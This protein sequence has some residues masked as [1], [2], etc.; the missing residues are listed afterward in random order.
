M[1]MIAFRAHISCTSC[2]L[3]LLCLLST[4]SAQ[5]SIPIGK[6]RTHISFNSVT[7]IT[8]SDTKVY[9][10][11]ANGLMVLDKGS[12]ELSAL[13]SLNGLTGKFIHAIHFDGISA[14]LLVGYED[15]SLDIIH[16]T[17]ITNL[18]WLQGIPLSVPRSANH[19]TVSGGLAYLSTG[20][21][22]AVI[23][24]AKRE[25]KEVWRDLA[26]DGSPLSIHQS[27]ILGDS[28]FLATGK[29]V[30]SGALGDNLLDFHKWNR[31]DTA[32]FDNPIKAVCSF[33][34]RIYAS[35]DGAGLFHL[36]GGTW[37]PEDFPQDAAV[38]SLTSSTAHLV[39]CVSD[40][41]WLLSQD[42][43]LDN[44]GSSFMTAFRY[45]WEDNDGR[46]WIADS[47][48]GLLSASD[49]FVAN[50]PAFNEPFRL[51]FLDGKIVALGGGYT[52]DF[53]PLERP[54][55]LSFFT[56]GKWNTQKA[57]LNDLTS[58]QNVGGVVF[59]S[60]YGNGIQSGP[61]DSPDVIYT[62]SNSS[63]PNTNIT[64][65]AVDGNGLW[66]A[67]YGAMSPLHW[68]EGGTWHP[69]SFP[70]TAARYPLALT[71]DYSGSL[72]AALSPSSGG[73]VLVFNREENLTAYLTD[74][75]GN[76][77]LP[78][79]NVRCLASDRDGAIWVGTDNG[80]AYF[81]N[82]AAV[83]GTDVNAT[84]PIYMNRFLLDGERVSAIA[85]DG[86]NR[87]WLGTERGVWLF[88]PDG[89][90]L[91]HNFTVANSP[92]PSNNIR[93]IAINGQDG[94]VFM[95]TDR[96]VVSFRSDATASDGNFSSTRIFP[97]PVTS[98]FNGM[99]GISGLAQ[100]AV[101]KITDISG[102]L[103]W[104]TRAAG[105]TASWNVRHYNGQ[106]ATT[107]IYLV[108]SA[109]DDGSQKFVGKIAVVD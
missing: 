41:V 81:S 93:N 91:I 55:S 31:Y 87:K 80:V 36:S 56:D 27:A 14:Q 34:G 18:N 25:V 85:V 71:V 47:A 96:G 60:S 103:V 63:L 78:H 88:G 15:G 48:N 104:Q 13:T 59:A 94:E 82:P 49:S 46:V 54:G 65:L 92:L 45:A 64:A 75:A 69:Y 1:T 38:Q 61:L 26:A 72:W 89:D 44:V 74:G 101:V 84:R 11:A 9:A 28:I 30:L 3:L 100:D 99:V 20:Y 66:A 73:G 98:E 76:G 29:G 6:W 5:E 77:G 102:R 8:G 33:M 70:V 40:N 105:G 42:N 109:T 23:D 53:Q 39:I 43:T 106:R 67:S 86:G 16:E 107:G 97:N 58:I 90:E 51:D 24:I 37:I 4:A 19:I 32:P 57:Q 17:G 10:A 52:S 83:F 68:F 22:V 12:M 2:C 95:A 7:A 79:R 50:G 62:T 35:S 21:G 108:F